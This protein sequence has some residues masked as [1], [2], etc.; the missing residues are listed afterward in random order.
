MKPEKTLFVDD[1][2]RETMKYIS[3]QINQTMNDFLRSSDALKT[4]EK[5][6]NEISK[7]IDTLK[8]LPESTQSAI[9]DTQKKNQQD[10]AKKLSESQSLLEDAIRSALSDLAKNNNKA[11]IGQIKSLDAKMEKIAEKVDYLSQ[12][13]YKKI[14]KKPGKNKP[15]ANKEKK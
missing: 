6:M 3:D 14:F 5:Q 7:G 1:A 12:P 8:K 4:I 13:F 9:K 15:K 10:I 11:L 2:T